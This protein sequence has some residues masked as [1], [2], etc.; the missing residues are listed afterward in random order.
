MTDL[1][2]I[3]ALPW[4]IVRHNTLCSIVRE[5]TSTRRSCLLDSRIGYLVWSLWLHNESD[6]I[7]PDRST[8]L[9]IFHSS[10]GIQLRR[11]LMHPFL[12]RQWVIGQNPDLHTLSTTNEKSEA[13]KIL[14]AACP[15]WIVWIVFF[16]ERFMSILPP[17]SFFGGCINFRRNCR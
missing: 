10:T 3:L 9:L 16:S 8:Y 5:H 13:N 1:F 14:V 11:K 12:F 17:P 2:H 7:H 4:Q 15:G 6:T